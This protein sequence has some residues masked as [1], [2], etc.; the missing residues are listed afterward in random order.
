MGSEAERQRNL[1]FLTDRNSG[2]GF[3]YGE[4]PDD[5]R[6]VSRANFGDDCEETG[7]GGVVR[8][9]TRFNG[10]RVGGNEDG[11]AGP[12]GGGEGEDSG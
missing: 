5:I 11:F 1:L 3:G 7:G 9:E 6:R 10:E 12:G 4:R 8:F 2:K